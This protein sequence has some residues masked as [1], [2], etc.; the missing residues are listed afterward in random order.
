MKNRPLSFAFV[1]LLLLGAC[2]IQKKDPQL[3]NIRGVVLG[4]TTP[5]LI[6]QKMEW[7]ISTRL[8]A[9]SMPLMSPCHTMCPIR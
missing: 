2:G 6:F 3:I 8:T 5:S 7:C 1:L 9:F 4:R